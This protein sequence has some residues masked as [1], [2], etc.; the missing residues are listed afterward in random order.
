MLSAYLYVNFLCFSFCPGHLPPWW[1]LYCY[2][3]VSYY[4]QNSVAYALLARAC[5]MCFP[6]SSTSSVATSSFP[7]VKWAPG[8]CIVIIYRTQALFLVIVPVSALRK[9]AE[10]AQHS[11]KSWLLITYFFF[12]FLL[13]RGI[14]FTLFLNLIYPIY[15]FHPPWFFFF[16]L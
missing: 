10:F 13:L 7:L 3:C 14:F 11:T 8:L 6:V 9:N 12:L 16:L 5:C 2:Y 4:V 15:L 1:R